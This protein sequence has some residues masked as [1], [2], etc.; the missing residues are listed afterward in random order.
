MSEEDQLAMVLK[1]SSEENGSKPKLE[2]L[3]EEEQLAA[4]LQMSAKKD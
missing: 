1:Q 3:N 4:V 2:N